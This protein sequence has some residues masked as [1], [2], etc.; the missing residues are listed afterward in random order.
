MMAAAMSTLPDHDEHQFDRAELIRHLCED[1]H[2]LAVAGMLAVFTEHF[3]LEGVEKT[4][5]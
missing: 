3:S 5:G 2:P 1:H 4:N